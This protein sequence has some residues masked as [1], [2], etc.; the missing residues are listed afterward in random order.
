M[1]QVTATD[2]GI[3]FRAGTFTTL[4]EALDYASQGATG[5]TFHGTDGAV[6]DAV[7]YRDLRHHATAL[8]ARL[9]GAFPRL[10]RIGLVAETS[11]EFLTAFMAC[12][13]AGLV[14]APLSLPAAFAGREAY[15]WQVSRM[16]ATARLA[17]VLAP[18]ALRGLLAEVMAPVGVPVHAL[19][20]GD[21]PGAPATPMP[22][23]AG[24]PAYIQFSS[25]STSDPKGIVATQASVAANVGAIIREGLAMTGADRMASWLPLYH[26][27]GM[28]GF[29]MVPLFA[30][31]SV[32]YIAPTSFARRPGSWLRMISD[33]RA[34][35]TYSP[36]FGYEL[37]TRRNRGPEVDLS[38]LRVAGIGGDMVRGDVLSAFA[39]TFGPSGFDAR[40][41]VPSYGLAEATLAVSFAPLG[42]GVRLDTIDLTTMQTTGHALAASDSLRA[43][44]RLRTF[45]SCGRPVPS[46]GLRILG[47]SGED[48]GEREVG[49]IAIRGGSLAAGYFRADEA[50]APVAGP[51]GWF[52][53][54]DL[55]Y[56]LGDE[57]VITGRSKDLI[58]WNGRNIWPQDIEWIAQTVGGSNVSRAA[59][60]DVG[61]D[62]GRTRILLL[63]ECWSRDAEVR[64]AL[65]RDIAAAARSAAGAPVE[66]HLVPVRTLPMTSSGKLSRAGARARFLAGGFA[67]DDAPAPAARPAAVPG[68]GG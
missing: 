23:D 24:G 59:A 66:V 16:A 50:L 33:R 51:D 18:D 20:G 46:F 63:A 41:F 31:V 19:S 25:G 1:G 45:V 67:Q 13:Y 62:D 43:D 61:E 57:V 4:T 15:E 26:D 54:G 47:K 29:F 10:A 11:A 14:P 3:P 53:T 21:L 28:V 42:G 27:M 9:A 5:L 32:D 22:H 17:A 68:L 38:C 44:A 7:P 64:E 65:V 55:G 56:W 35:I 6:A 52:E 12:Q 37:C 34:T 48:L 40:A 36:S 2:S 39:A 30:Q 60:F 58:L 49:R 8:A